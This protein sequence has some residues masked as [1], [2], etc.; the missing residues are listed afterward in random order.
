MLYETIREAAIEKANQVNPSKSL[1]VYEKLKIENEHLLE[2]AR[3]KNIKQRIPIGLLYEQ[4]LD[5]ENI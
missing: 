4:L 3:R 5:E 2:Q 1:S